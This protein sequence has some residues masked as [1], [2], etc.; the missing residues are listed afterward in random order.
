M[1]QMC[2]CLSLMTSKRLRELGHILEKLDWKMLTE[3]TWLIE[4][5]LIT[6]GLYPSLLLMALVL[7]MRAVSMFCDVFFVEQFAMARRS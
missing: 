5:L 1:I 6:L 2:S 7:V 3:L 4:W